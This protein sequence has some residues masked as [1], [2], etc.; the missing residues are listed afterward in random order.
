MELGML[1][2]KKITKHVSIIH[3]FSLMSSL[4]R[5]I[6]NVLLFEAIKSDNWLNHNESIA[7]ECRIPFSILYKSINFKSNNTQYLKE[8]IDELAS[9]TIEWN[10]LKDKVPND[11]SF[12]NLRI[13]HGSPTF[14]QDGTFNFS[15]HKVMLQ[16]IEKPSIYGTIDIDLQSQFE[17]KYSHALYEN[18]TRFVNLQKNKIIQ[19]EIFRK[20]LG[21]QTNKYDGMRELTRNV[22]TPSIEEVNDRADFIVDL[23][24]ISLGRK[25]TGFLLSV[26]SKSKHT[27]KILQT[28]RNEKNNILDEIKQSF[29]EIKTNILENILK[30]YSEQYIYE[31]I[32]YTKKFSKKELT[33]FYPIPYFISA[34]KNDYKSR[35]N[36]QSSLHEEKSFEQKDDW[37][38][39]LYELQS[40]L[41]HWKKMLDYGQTSRNI[42]CIK[43]AKEA[44]EKYEQKYKQHL[45]TKPDKDKAEEI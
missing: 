11:I 26:N 7:V 4:Q 1:A 37:G 44:I 3:A 20:L 14:F 9:L 23:E 27:K 24:K 34:L 8:A 2:E 41:N 22:I 29:G 15:F 40:Q 6:V 32:A 43:T 18:C 38:N 21:V 12:L 28:D 5:K 42:A 39:E 19:L 13:L 30:N 33:G 36:Y 16:L 45:L 17:S 25:V 31:K 10:L 35:E